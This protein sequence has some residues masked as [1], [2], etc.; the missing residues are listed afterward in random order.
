MITILSL[1]PNL[2]ALREWNQKDSE[3]WINHM[4]F[5]ISG[6][7]GRNLAAL[8]RLESLTLNLPAGWVLM[9]CRF[10]LLAFGETQGPGVGEGEGEGRQGARNSSLHFHLQNLKN[11]LQSFSLSTSDNSPTF[12]HDRLIALSHFHTQ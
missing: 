2:D 7:A 12:T 8:M 10:W 1:F 6:L 4:Q 5:L 3:P 11:Q 9:S